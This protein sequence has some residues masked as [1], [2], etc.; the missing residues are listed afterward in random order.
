MNS[1]SRLSTARTPTCC[2][3][4]SVTATRKEQPS[5]P[6]TKAS[7][8]GRTCSPETKSSPPQSSTAYCTTA[9]S[10]TSTEEATASDKWKP[11]ST[12]NDPNIMRETGRPPTAG[13][14]TSIDSVD[15]GGYRGLVGVLLVP[16][17]APAAH[18]LHERL[19]ALQSGAEAENEG[20][21]HLPEPRGLLASHHC[22]VRGAER[23]V[24]IGQEVLRRGTAR[25]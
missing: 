24:V 23:G 18:P 13:N 8:N 12:T 2:S 3:K 17:A 25:G 20:G 6:A 11:R 22:H 5:S 21:S 1:A 14:W 15:P 16:G 19:G 4:S 7:A 10:S 9:T